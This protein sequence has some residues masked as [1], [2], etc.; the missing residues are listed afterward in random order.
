[1]DFCMSIKL[2][3]A[4][5]FAA[6]FSVSWFL[7]VLTVPRFSQ[8]ALLFQLG[9]IIAQA[10]IVLFPS[11]TIAAIMLGRSKNSVTAM[12]TWW[13]LSLL[14]AAVL[15]IGALQVAQFSQA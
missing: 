8:S 10:A 14:I 2:W 15:T 7:G 9:H 13:V 3:A 1:M 6:T 4:M 5:L 11:G 12:K